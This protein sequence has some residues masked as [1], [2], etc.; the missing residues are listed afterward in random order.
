VTPDAA[1]T[2]TYTLTCTGS[3]GSA[4]ASAVLAATAVGVTISAHSGGGGA[5][6]MTVL[7]LLAGLVAVRWLVRRRTGGARR[8]VP[9]AVLLIA[10]A[11]GGWAHACTSALRERPYLG[12]RVGTVPLSMP[13]GRIDAVRAAGGFGSETA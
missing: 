7:T 11:A 4:S 5:L 8:V 13:T 9:I 12:V 1:G 6:S 3:G 2:Q 10:G